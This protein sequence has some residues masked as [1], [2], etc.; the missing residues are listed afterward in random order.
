MFTLKYSDFLISVVKHEHH[1]YPKYY[2]SQ[3]M[4]R[5]NHQKF[6]SYSYFNRAFIMQN[7]NI[8]KTEQEVL[9]Y[10]YS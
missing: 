4:D 5:H 6:Y 7:E 10:I 1:K 9:L 3:L 2:G 8:F